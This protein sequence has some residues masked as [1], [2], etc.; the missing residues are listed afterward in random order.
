[1]RVAGTEENLKDLE[2]VAVESIAADLTVSVYS[3]KVVSM[4]MFG[5]VLTEVA[6]LKRFFT[7]AVICFSELGCEN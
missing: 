4:S 3:H 1:M 6:V 7:I 5:K 2:G